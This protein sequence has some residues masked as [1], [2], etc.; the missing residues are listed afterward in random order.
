MPQG[1]LSLAA[2]VRVRREVPEH[3]LTEPLTYRWGLAG[4]LLTPLTLP[5]LS[6]RGLEEGI[7][8]NDRWSVERFYA[9]GNRR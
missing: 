6:L 9:G 1:K 4:P 2:G 7:V 8:G 3:A 5:V